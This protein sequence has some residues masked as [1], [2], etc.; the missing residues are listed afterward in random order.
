MTDDPTRPDDATPNEQADATPTEQADATPTER[1]DAS[2]AEQVAASS[3]HQADAPPSKQG[4]LGKTLLVAAIAFLAVGVAVKGCS[5]SSN[6]SKSDPPTTTSTDPTT[7]LLGLTASTP[8]ITEGTSR[9]VTLDATYAPDVTPDSYTW[10]VV[11]DGS[12]LVQPT[13]AHA[14]QARYG[15]ARIDVAADVLVTFELSATWKG[16][17]ESLQTSVVIRSVDM[18]P[19]MGPYVQIG[20]Q[21][22]VTE[23]LSHEGGEWVLYN[24]CNRLSSTPITAPAG[25]KYSV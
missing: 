20:G 24:V 7:F 5:K 25:D 1:A 8:E 19:A 9:Q 17:T 6:K 12:R 14:T 21:S 18:V 3:S 11:G 16:R 13:S 10:S 23:S 2:P 15:A 4:G 22:T